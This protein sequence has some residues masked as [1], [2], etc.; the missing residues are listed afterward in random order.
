LAE[1]D[2]YAEISQSGKGI[3]QFVF[4]EIPGGL[5]KFIRHIDDEPFIG[6]SLPAIE[7]YQSGRVCA[8][9]GEH[10][11]GSGE[12]VVED[13]ALLDRLCW[14][15]GTGENKATDTPTDPF[16]HERGDSTD[17]TP[18]H[19]TVARAVREAQTYAGTDPE[20]WNVREGRSL[21]YEAVLRARERSGDLSAV[22]NW[23]LIGYAA[24]L[25]CRDGL[26]QEEVL[27]DL[28]AH[29]TPQYGYDDSRAR[30][31][32]RGVYRKADDG[33]YNP[34]TRS[35]LAERGILPN[36]FTQANY[37]VETC[38]P[39]TYDPDTFNRRERWERLQGTRYDAVR[40][41]DGV[42]IWN[43]P[44]GSGK[45][46]NAT[47][48]ALRRDQN[49]ALLFD[50]HEKAREVQTDDA[51][52]EGFDPYHLKGAEQKRHARCMDADHAGEECSEHGH[53]ANCPSMCPV[54]DLDPDHETRRR[55]DAVAREVGD[56][57]AHL[58]LG[59]TL[60]NHDD[61]VCPWV[62]QFEEVEQADHVV[63]VHEYQRLKTVRD[64]R[65]VI[66]DESPSSLRETE[67]VDIEGL[68]RTASALEDLANVLPRDDPSKYTAR[69]FAGFVN[70]LIDTATNDGDLSDLEPP[71]VVWNAYESYDDAAGNYVEREKPTE[72]WHTAEALAQLKVAY[73]ETIIDRIKREEW[74]GTPV[75]LDPVITAAGE[76]G[77]SP[78]AVRAAV[79]T[80]NVLDSCPW[81]N[82]PVEPQNGARV[83]GSDT[84]DWGEHEH[85]ITQQ[86]GERARALAYVADAPAGVGFERLPLS[87]SLPSDPLILDATAT[88][89]KVAHLYGVAP[90]AVDVSGDD[91]L[92]ANMR[93]VQVENGQY[94]Y[95]TIKE[96]DT[97]RERVQNTIDKAADVHDK[98]LFV[99]KKGLRG[100]FDFP[101]HA[102]T[103]HYHAV[104]GLNRNDCDAVVCVGAPHANVPDLKR[105]AELLAQGTNTR[106]GGGEHSTRRDAPNPPIYRRLNFEDDQGRGRAVP[107]KH[108]TGLVGALFRETR[109][110]EI[111]QAVHRARPLLAEEEVDVYLLTNVPT[112]LRV[113]TMCTFEELA[114]PLR[115]L[116]PVRDGAIEL[117]GAVEQ[118]AQGNGPDGFRPERLVTTADDGTVSHKVAEY[119][120]LAILTGLDVTERT[121]RNYIDDL[122]AVGLLEAEA[123]EQRAGVSYTADRSTLKTALS[124]LTNNA[125][126]KVPARR[127]LRRKM[128]KAGSVAEWLDWARAVFGLGGDRCDLDP[129]P[130]PAP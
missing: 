93:V 109:E 71:G 19:D 66:I 104:R 100:L 35:R 61:G 52:P 96:S 89:E 54:K 110:K 68:V 48:G 40:E 55:Y 101:D 21:E 14:E 15:Y 91:D 58:L 105:E 8:M 3:H 111:E 90:E 42:S 73:T 92:Q 116:L 31:E 67:H 114:E 83:C 107:T 70:E 77:L 120:R 115:A 123:Y 17:T 57:K 82:A 9:T 106:I 29:P 24:A 53:T 80:P 10:V 36:R 78:D 49:V 47:L 128:D 25:G 23:E 46:T 59:E 85:T 30:K 125:A 108:Y 76:A 60:P 41:H 86:D 126:F 99:I 5:K 13:Q 79:A 62:D 65:R 117:L 38:E 7:M 39:P 121:V 112:S 102:E 1:C 28:E 127:L 84:C 72:E 95:S 26:D 118:V 94:H 64:G 27:A 16:A 122:Q 12:D 44:A 18:D 33:N 56:V 20:E 97:A 43:D 50:K 87:S 63:G 98:P 103:L 37:E 81:C 6:D 69:E 45:T 124:V 88:P 74:D 129:P 34:P 2:G 51:L 113:D 4:G 130:D 75:G 32:V 22:A 11:K 119:H